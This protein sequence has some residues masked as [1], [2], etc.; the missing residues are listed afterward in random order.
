[1]KRTVYLF[2]GIV[3]LFLFPV[4]VYS[5]ESTYR[6]PVIAGDF[7]DPTVIRVGDT[8]FAAGTSSEWAPPYRLYESKDFD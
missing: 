5:Q 6:N 1:M 8:Y 3:T 2:A 4:M 7:P